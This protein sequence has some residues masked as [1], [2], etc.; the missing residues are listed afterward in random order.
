MP[1]LRDGEER[2]PDP[3]LDGAHGANEAGDPGTRVVLQ[4]AM[5]DVRRAMHGP[6][7]V[8]A[9]RVPQSSVPSGIHPSKPVSVKVSSPSFVS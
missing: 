3:H 9:W 6:G 1:G 7:E 2:D 4:R 5:R 8:A